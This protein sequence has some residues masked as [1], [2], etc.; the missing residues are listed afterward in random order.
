[1]TAWRRIQRTQDDT[2]ASEVLV[3]FHVPRNLR[4]LLLDGKHF[5]IGRR[6]YTLY[7]ALD[8]ALGLPVCWILLPRYELREGYDIILS[9]LKQK[10][11]RIQAVVSDWH[12]GIRGSVV[13]YYPHAVHQRCAAHVLRDVLRKCGGKKF[14]GSEYGKELWKKIRHVALEYDQLARARR[15]LVRLKRRYP[16]HIRAW[17]EL[18]GCLADIYQFEYK[19]RLHIPRTSNRIENFMGFLEQRLKTMRGVKTPDT[20]AA[21][22]TSLIRLK[23]KKPTNR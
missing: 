14:I 3:V 9:H 2:A 15:Q 8:G 19:P 11:C 17:K 5:R 23:Y 18:S 7:V 20:L 16:V 13:E 22:L 6:P 10:K 4:I 12:P 1:M 21:L